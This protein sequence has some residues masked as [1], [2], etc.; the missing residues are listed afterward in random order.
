MPKPTKGAAP[1][2]KDPAAHQRHIIANLCKALIEQSRSPPRSPVPRPF[3]PT[4]RS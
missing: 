2:C 3:S 4:W 1:G